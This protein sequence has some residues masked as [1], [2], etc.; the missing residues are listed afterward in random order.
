[1][2]AIVRLSF[3]VP[4]EIAEHGNP[5]VRGTGHGH[6]NEGN[7]GVTQGTNKGPDIQGISES[8]LPGNGKDNPNQGIK[9]GNSAPQGNNQED[10]VSQ[11]VFA[12]GQIS[13]MYVKHMISMRQ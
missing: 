4:R 3:S 6:G 1:M 10:P 9:G 2:L 8:G 7:P 11:N 5:H 12:V 13:G